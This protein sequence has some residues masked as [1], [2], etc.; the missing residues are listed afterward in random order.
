MPR[1]GL[2]L[3]LIYSDSELMQIRV[4]AWNGA[5][6]GAANVYVGIGLI[7]K[8]AE[9]LKGFPNGPSDKREVV[10]G[11]F[12]SEFAGGAVSLLFHCADRAGH[13][14]VDLKIESDSD[15]AGRCQSV[16]FSLPI[17][18]AGMDSFV[19]DL[20]RLGAGRAEEAFLPAIFGSSR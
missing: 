7:E 8:I 18:A 20:G 3:K 19:N 13:A 16:T 6:G 1:I 17:D 12:G 5:F 11:A 4:S 2:K 9:R 15:I 10:L 14:Y